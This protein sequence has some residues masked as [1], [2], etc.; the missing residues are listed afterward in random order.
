MKFK[1]AIVLSFFVS[2]GM[3]WF[4]YAASP[5]SDMKV[6]IELYKSWSIW[7]VLAQLAAIMFIGIVLQS[8]RNSFVGDH[9]HSRGLRLSPSWIV[10]VGLSFSITSVMIVIGSG[11]ITGQSPFLGP[12]ELRLW[13]SYKW[14]CTNLSDIDPESSMLLNGFLAVQL[15]LN[16]FLVLCVMSAKF[17]IDHKE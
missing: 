10:A 7:Q 16:T 17:W 3:P 8:I 12:N 15:F 6:I 2:S 4:F 1:N 5:Y 9:P 11:G 13:L 14:V